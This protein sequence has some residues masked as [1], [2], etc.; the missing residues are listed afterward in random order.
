MS[1]RSRRIV[2]AAWPPFGWLP[3][4]T[5]VSL[6][7]AL[8]ACSSDGPKAAASI[9]VTPATVSLSPSSPTAAI[10]ASVKDDKGGSL[11]SASVTWSSGAPTVAIV[12]PSGTTATITAVSPG[13]ATITAT[14]GGVSAPVQV[15]V[16][17]VRSVVVT[18]SAAAIRVGDTQTLTAA[19]TADPGLPTTVTWA[20]DNPAVATVSAAGVVTGVSIGNAT[21]RA[22]SVGDARFSATATFSVTAQRSVTLAPT[23][24]SIVA[25]DQRT[26]VPTVRMDAG[27]STAVTWR[28]SAAAVATVSAAGVVTGVANGTATITAVAVADT[29]VRATAVVTVLPSVRTVTVAPTTASVFWGATQQFTSTVTVDGTISNAVTWRSS[30]AAVATVSNS[31]LVTTT[32]VGTATITVLSTADTTKRATATLT[33]NSRTTTVAITQR[34]VG[35]NPGGSTALTATVS[36]NPGVATGVTWSSS[37]AGVASIN[38]SGVVTAVALGSAVITASAVADPT[39]RDTVT[40]SVLPVLATNWTPAR[41]NGPLYD[42]IQSIVSFGSSTAFA[43]N[44][45]GDVFLWN[46]SVWTASSRGATYS[47]RF[48]SVHGTA[49]NNVIAVGTN[50]AIIKWDGVQWTTMSSGTTRVL[51]NVFVDSLGGAFA[52]GANGTALRLAG[53]N[54]SS[55][56][57]GTVETLNGVWSSNGVSYAVG[58]AGVVLRFA[59]NTWSTVSVP[60]SEALNAIS[61]TSSSNIIA[62]GSFGTILRFDGTNWSIVPNNE[63]GGDMWAVQATTANN[64]RSY[65]AGDDGLLQLD[66]NTV[67]TTAT[68]YAPNLFTV[69][70]D[71]SGSVWTGGQRGVVMRAASGSNTFQT[72]SIAPDLLDV[73]T[74]SSTNSWAV[75]EF[76][77]AYRWN[78]S[79]WTRDTTPTLAAL[80]AVWAPA[81]NEAFAGG[82]NGTILRWTGGAWRTMAF[83]SLANVTSIWGTS[84]S[85]VYAVTDAGEIVRYAGTSWSVVATAPRA[86]T[87]IFG[88]NASEVYAG[89]EG[90]TMLRFNGTT[91][92]Q[93]PTPANGTIVGLWMS[94]ITDVTAVGADATGDLGL[95][96]RFDGNAWQQLSLGTRRVLTSIWGPSLNDIYVTGDIGTLLRYDGALW[97]PVSLPT[98]DLLWSVSGAPDAS[99]GAFA[100]GYN[101][102]IV[103]G[104][105]GPAPLFASLSAGNRGSLEPSAAARRSKSALMRRTIPSGAARAKRKHR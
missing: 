98:T 29:L 25:G 27:L 76:G 85:N 66:G 58:T 103:T 38:T 39:R 32:G 63:R 48:L 104:A 79:A 16:L 84:N 92:S 90:G 68:P 9:V 22:T 77:F 73:W 60:T 64:G 42:D 1:S 40:V 62:V 10:T 71:A 51:N 78:G 33:V 4:L 53:G 88:V 56:A 50:G 13:T 28:T 30:N 67:S 59:G 20:S 97:Q 18:P 46:G 6:L 12:S 70:M 102:L 105:K 21:I 49:F 36:A 86:L 5:G 2:R 91:W 83:P 43:V 57:T 23:S 96:Y 72:L 94:G 14:S 3:L 82:D 87:A 89:G 41:L 31:G 24:V 8:A 17:G 75:G 35:L 15:Q 95:A 65:I 7:S 74:T 55:T 81:A 54:W 93:L 80:N 47:T 19:V 61:G 34:T 26:L 101:S 69:H 44:L 45:A 100:V 37:N 99:G 11:S 52:V